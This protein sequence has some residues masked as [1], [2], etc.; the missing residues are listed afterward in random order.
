MSC[1][2]KKVHSSVYIVGKPVYS[3]GM[4]KITVNGY[5]V[6]ASTAAE[7]AALLRELAN[8]DSAKL[9]RPKLNLSVK[10]GANGADAALNFLTAVTGAGI[11]GAN[12]DLVMKALG[13]A[14]PKGVGGR[15]VR[16]NNLLVKLGFSPED[17]YRKIRTP[18]GKRWR[19]ANK[20]QLAITAIKQERG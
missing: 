5:E 14:E 16:V 13:T 3:D 11:H 2:E 15:L 18:D 19:A 10:N 8:T 20:L 6:T 7:I 12:S 4:I 9:G 17:V 1:P